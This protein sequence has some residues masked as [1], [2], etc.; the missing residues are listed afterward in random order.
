M[1]IKVEV[2]EYSNFSKELRDKIREVHV[3]QKD[4]FLLLRTD[5]PTHFLQRGR[6]GIRDYILTT[7]YRKDC[8]IT[9]EL[10][11]GYRDDDMWTYLTL[12][13][14]EEYPHLK[15]LKFDYLLIDTCW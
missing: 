14:M 5:I 12:E 2:V 13:I 8:D 3:F 9:E 4:V 7:G 11:D 6:D 1:A 10:I 15:S